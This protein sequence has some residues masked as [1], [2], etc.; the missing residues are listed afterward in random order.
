[1]VCVAMSGRNGINLAEAY[2]VVP[3]QM[4]KGATTTYS[5][6]TSVDQ[7]DMARYDPQGFYNGMRVRCGRKQF[8]LC[9][10]PVIFVADSRQ[11]GSATTTQPEQM[12]LDLF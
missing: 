9:G 7:G 11:E 4:F 10:P 3:L 8:V 2:R 1:M 5:E 12:Q 6:K